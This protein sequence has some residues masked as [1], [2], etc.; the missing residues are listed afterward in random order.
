MLLV[1]A[2][3]AWYRMEVVI[4]LMAIEREMVDECEFTAEEQTHVTCF[5]RCGSA[6]RG[7]STT[8]GRTVG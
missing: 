4:L 3:I 8:A 6:A 5:S 7:C 2:P 1:L